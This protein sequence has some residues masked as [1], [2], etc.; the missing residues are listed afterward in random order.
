VG[1]VQWLIL[2]S[3][4]RQAAD[5]GTSSSRMRSPGVPEVPVRLGSVASFSGF[6]LGLQ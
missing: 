5:D 4:K 6:Q 3:A 1:L 2:G